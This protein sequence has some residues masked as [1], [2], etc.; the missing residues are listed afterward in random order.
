[1]HEH[2]GWMGVCRNDQH[3][4]FSTIVIIIMFLHGQ[5]D[6]RDYRVIYLNCYADK[7]FEVVCEVS[8]CICMCATDS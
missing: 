5:D 8:T 2:K 7:A 1:M 3:V 4:M 6:E